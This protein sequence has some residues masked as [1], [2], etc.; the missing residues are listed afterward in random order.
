MCSLEQ[1]QYIQTNYITMMKKI[2]SCQCFSNKFNSENLLSWKMCCTATVC[3]L[4]SSLDPFWYFR[5]NFLTYWQQQMESA[6]VIAW[7]WY[8]ALMPYLYN[9]NVKSHIWVIFLQWQ[10]FAT[11][12]IFVIYLTRGK[13][14]GKIDAMFV[15]HVPSNCDFIA[16]VLYFTA[17]RVCTVTICHT[18]YF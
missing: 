2:Y 6:T 11:L 15:S 16:S 14:K 5:S 18:K 13:N 12:K 17:I 9:K 7:N 4:G 1:K 3:P 8:A 10:R